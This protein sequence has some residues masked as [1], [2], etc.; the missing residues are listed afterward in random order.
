MDIKELGITGFVVIGGAVY[1]ISEYGLGDVL[2]DDLKYVSEVPYA[3]REAYMQSVSVQFTEFY[4]GAIFGTD[5][6][7]L[8]GE[9][10]YEL[11]P[12]KTTFIE[13]IASEDKVSKEQVKEL[14]SFY[15][16]KWLCDTEDA[17]LFTHKGWTYTTKLK[18]VDGR[19]M[20]NVT[21]RPS[22]ASGLRS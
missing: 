3:D 20:V 21:C 9:M 7:S 18:N 6:F 4:G 13:V 19:T 16:D 14:K 12:K 2:Q 1:G 15:G 8:V 11:D 17:L 22:N 10:T 5:D